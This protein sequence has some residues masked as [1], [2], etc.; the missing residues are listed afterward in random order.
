MNVS[1]SKTVEEKKFCPIGS[2]SEISSIFC[3]NS[4]G[5]V[6]KS[7]PAVFRKDLFARINLWRYHL[8]SLV[9]A[10]G[11]HEPEHR[12]Q[13]A[14][15]RELGRTTRFNAEAKAEYLKFSLSKTSPLVGKFP[16]VGL[17]HHRLSASGN[18]G[19][20]TGWIGFGRCWLK[21]RLARW[22]ED[23][24]QCVDNIMQAAWSL[25]YF[26]RMQLESN[27]FRFLPE[28]IKE[29]WQRQAGHCSMFPVWPKRKTR[30]IAI[31]YENIWRNSV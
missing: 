13:L 1:L 27:H 28:S 19:A 10:A 23:A 6:Q 11:D 25:G 24:D 5:C 31:G 2:D 22:I 12:T 14:L 20:D 4:H 30:T 16:S 15:S 7:A 18:T 26:D 3:R 21:W 17:Q 29:V 8:P 9:Q